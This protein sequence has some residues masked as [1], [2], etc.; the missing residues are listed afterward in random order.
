MDTLALG[1]ELYKR[2]YLIRKAEEFIIAEYPKNE[3]KTPMHMSMGEEAIAAGVCLALGD[4]GQVL[5]SYRSH[6]VYLA[7]TNESDQFF[8]EL[9]GRVTG[10][11]KGKAG[12]MHLSN[13]AL[14]HL[15][16]SA[17]LATCIPVA[18][19]AAFANKRKRNGKIVAVFFGE[20]AMDEGVFWESVNA[21]SAMRLEVMFI[22][23]DNGLA[24]H[25]PSSVRQ[26]Y[27]SITDV[28]SQFSCSVFSSEST[29]AEEIHRLTRQA[30]QSIRENGQP[31]FL[32][33]KYY[34]YLEHLGIGKDFDAGYRSEAEFKEWQRRDP[35]SLQRQKLLDQGYSEE[36]LRA[37]ETGIDQQILSSVAR[38]RQAPRPAP[39]ELSRNVFS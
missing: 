15:G 22:C 34:R 37:I 10:V 14:G 29:D 7:K 19:G 4:E 27:R 17:V 1:V 5:A 2:V 38:A 30:M 8:A 24:V 32:H 9:Y 12:S 23:E 18:L 31:A 33:L 16:S 28:I 25:T 21:A 39:E 6:A 13:P 11:A 36:G 26:G 35:V 3:M 20:G